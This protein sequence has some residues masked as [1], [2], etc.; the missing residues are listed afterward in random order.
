MS[1]SGIGAMVQS[2]AWMSYRLDLEV[3][4]FGRAGDAPKDSCLLQ[5]TGRFLAYN[6]LLD[7][8]WIFLSAQ[9][10]DKADPP[11]SLASFADGPDGWKQVCAIVRGLE[12][13]QIKSLAKPIELGGGSGPNGWVIS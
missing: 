9:L 12:R 10:M 6:V 5:M 7:G 2:A 1:D 13:D 3:L 8:G 11:E 4:T